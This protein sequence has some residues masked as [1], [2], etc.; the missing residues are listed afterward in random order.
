MNVNM[1]M[2]DVF[3]SVS[4]NQATTRA[5]V[6]LGLDSQETAIIVWVS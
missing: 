2:V 5:L 3:T 4:T 1:K 6:F